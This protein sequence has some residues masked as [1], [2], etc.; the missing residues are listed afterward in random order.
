MKVVKVRIVNDS[1]DEKY[2][3]LNEIS[4]LPDGI[5]IVRNPCGMEHERIS[6]IRDVIYTYFASKAPWLPEGTFLR[7]TNNKDEI[8]LLESGK[9]HASINHAYNKKE[10]GLSVA[11]HPGYGGL[12]YKYCYRIAG[13]IIA[14]GS[15]GEPILALNSLRAIDKKPMKAAEV[16]NLLKPAREAALEKAFAEMGWNRNQWLEPILQYAE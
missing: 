3:H 2:Q 13:E 7:F 8:R 9:L 12:G 6:K 5:I 11:N 4:I 16:E 10:R 14:H 15:D 1:G